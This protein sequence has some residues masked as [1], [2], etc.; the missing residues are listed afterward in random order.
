[1]RK[2]T[3]T[4]KVMMGNCHKNAISTR[5]PLSPHP[6]IPSVCCCFLATS[7]SHSSLNVGFMMNASMSTKLVRVAE[8]KVKKEK[9]DKTEKISKR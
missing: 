6:S 7:R 8:A 2:A 4:A 5:K 3:S 1:M 9:R